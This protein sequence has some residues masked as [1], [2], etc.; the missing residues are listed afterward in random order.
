VIGLVLAGVLQGHIAREYDGLIS[1]LEP[2]WEMTEAEVRLR[3][4]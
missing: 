1:D 2:F 4:F 3:V